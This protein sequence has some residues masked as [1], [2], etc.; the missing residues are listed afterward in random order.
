MEYVKWLE[1]G[2]SQGR[3]IVGDLSFR[4]KYRNENSKDNW[5]DVGG[6]LGLEPET[7]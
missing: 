6:K 5:Q 1:V 3:E 4:W 2:E 7:D